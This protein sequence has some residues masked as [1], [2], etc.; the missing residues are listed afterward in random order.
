LTKNVTS[1]PH[2]NCFLDEHR[3]HKHKMNYRLVLSDKGLGTVMTGKGAL[4]VGSVD[5]GGGEV[6]LGEEESL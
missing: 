2:L 6:E 3:Q 1:I 4:P 5:G